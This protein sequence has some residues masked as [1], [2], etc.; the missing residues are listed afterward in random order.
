MLTT[1]TLSAAAPTARVHR[2]RI[3][4]D[5]DGH[6]DSIVLTEGPHT[7]VLVVISFYDS[8]H[9]PERFH[10]P[11]DPSMQAAVCRLP[12]RLR[13]ES[14]DYD[15]APAV[16]SLPGFVRSKR[17][18]GFALVDEACDSIHFYWDARAQ[19]LRWWRA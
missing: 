7:G 15:P 6:P 10:F 1:M 17:R 18:T 12:V 14:L 2:L 16:G 11:V 3:D 8:R 9:A 19:R 4:I 5:G 13:A